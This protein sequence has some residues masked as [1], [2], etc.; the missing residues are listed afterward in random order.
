MSSIH[1]SHPLWTLPALPAGV[2]AS[3]N[4]VTAATGAVTMFQAGP[5]GGA[6][7]GTLTVV[8]THGYAT[9]SNL[10]IVPG[11]IS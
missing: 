3:G 6:F 4:T 2:I 11:G 9:F 7:S 5:G 8:A 1:F 10:R